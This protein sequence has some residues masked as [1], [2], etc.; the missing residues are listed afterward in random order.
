MGR[1]VIIEPEQKQGGKLTRHVELIPRMG[2]RNSD[3]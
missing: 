3:E 2:I 1:G